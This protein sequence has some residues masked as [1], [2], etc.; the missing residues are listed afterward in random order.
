MGLYFCKSKLTKRVNYVLIKLSLFFTRFTL[1][2][3]SCL[4][5]NHVT[6]GWTVWCHIS[7]FPF[8]KKFVVYFNIFA[9]YNLYF[10]I[11][12]AINSTFN[13]LK[14]KKFSLARDT[15]KTVVTHSAVLWV[16]RMV[17]L[18]SKPPECY[19]K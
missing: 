15:L 5:I 13:C 6:R 7:L 9:F 10:L 1:C 19:F 14:S 3:V 4:P 8:L 18:A 17:T 11:I 16:F 2:N 12:K